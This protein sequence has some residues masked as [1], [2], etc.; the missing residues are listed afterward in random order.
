MINYHNNV[1]NDADH[2]DIEYTMMVVAVVVIVY[3]SGGC[4]LGEQGKS[5]SCDRPSN[6]NKIESK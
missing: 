6:F 1:E 3:A 5:D 4:V 2:H